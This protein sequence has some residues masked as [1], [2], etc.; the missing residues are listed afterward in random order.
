MSSGF[1]KAWYSIGLKGVRDHPPTYGK[2]SY[3]ELPPLP[4]ESLDESFAWLSSREPV[5]ELGNHFLDLYPDVLAELCGDAEVLHLEIPD[6]FVEFMH[7]AELSQRVYSAT[8][9]FFELGHHLVQVPWTSGWLLRFLAD[10]QGCL[11]WYLFLKPGDGHCVVVGSH[12]YGGD[13]AIS[14]ELAKQ[15]FGPD[16]DWDHEDPPERSHLICECAPSF[17]EFIYRFCLENELWSAL[18]R[19]GGPTNP[20]QAEYVSHY[21]HGRQLD[22]GDRG[23]GEGPCSTSP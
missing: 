11:Y 7:S 19:T 15:L 16:S 5:Q 3:E 17:V 9:C 4:N 10:C 6:A 21:T 13:P 23:Q 12:R 14:P 8:G 18:T 1:P 22:A 2:F 20:V